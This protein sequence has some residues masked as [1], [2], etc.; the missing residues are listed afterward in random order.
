MAEKDTAIPVLR[1]TGKNGE[2][3][4][5]MHDR[6]DEGTIPWSGERLAEELGSH[7][8]SGNKVTFGAIHQGKLIGFEDSK[9]KPAAKKPASK[10][11]A[12]TAA[13]AAP[14]PAAKPAAKPVAKKPAAKAAPKKGK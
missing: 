11:A 5:A 12:K 7:A 8:K 4:S 9:S 3:V 6:T 14:K 2:G 1:W 10:A 13:K